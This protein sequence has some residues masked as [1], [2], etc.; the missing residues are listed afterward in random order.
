MPPAVEDPKTKIMNIVPTNFTVADFC[1]AMDRGEIVVNRDYQRSDKVWP[2]AARSFFLETIL[3]GLPFPKLSL[4]QV[5]DLRSKKTYKEIV[6]GQQ[7]S[8]TIHD[9]FKDKLR[10]SSALDTEDIAGKTYSELGDDYKQRF[11]DYQLSID[12]FVAATPDEVREVFRRMNSYTVP[13]NPEEH[14]HASYQGPFKWFVQ[15]I[16]R[17]FDDGFVQIGLFGEKQ[18]VR[19]ADTKLIAE[20]CHALIYGIETT[21]KKKLDRLYRDREKSFSEEKEI[22]GRITSAFDQILEWSVIHGGA[23]MKPYIVYS[24][25]LAISHTRSPVQSLENVYQ[26]PRLKVFET[27]IVMGNLTALSEALENP[28]TAGPFAEFVSACSSK[29]NVRDQRTTRFH[30]LCRAL[31][32]EPF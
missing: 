30:W 9:F 12:L 25:I 7:R 32:S 31:Q 18:L 4:Y 27:D 1:H 28:D 14:R 26:S 3:L 19:M 13:L 5:T 10:L 21:N 24:L 23:L 16:S 11:L 20:I 6:D 17:R 29:T 8:I 22:D 15:R 2:A